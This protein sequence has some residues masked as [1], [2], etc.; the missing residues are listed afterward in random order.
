M[1][2]QDEG[3]K[4]AALFARKLRQQQRKHQNELAL[5]V[6]GTCLFLLTVMAVTNELDK[7][8]QQQPQQQANGAYT[9][10]GYAGY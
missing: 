2:N 4:L 7:R 8:Q 5:A 9:G 3:A 10:Y 1:S 6:G